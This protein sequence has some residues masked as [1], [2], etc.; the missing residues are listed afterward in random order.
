VNRGDDLSVR[1][2][3]Q[4]ATASE[5]WSRINDTG[6]DK[7]AGRLVRA[8]WSGRSVRG[9][10]DA[11]HGQL[12]RLISELEMLCGRATEAM[13][14]A[15]RALA[16]MDLSLSEQVIIDDAETGRIHTQFEQSACRLLALQ[17][18]VAG[19]LRAVVSMIEVGEKVRRMSGL[20]CHVAEAAR[21][22]HPEPAVPEQLARRF[23]EMGQVGVY[24]CRQVRGAVDRPA[25]VDVGELDRLDDR[26]DELEA[27]VLVVRLGFDLVQ[28]G[29]AALDFGDDVLGGGFPDEGF[30][31]VVP[32]FGPGGDGVGEVGDAGEHAAT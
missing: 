1:K 29:A 19:E 13:S 15:A 25:T 5:L 7:S 2:A 4:V 11:Y 21:R 23:T 3:Y 28:G 27:S 32:V 6:F 12:G 22:R 10:R 14:N 18:P 9:M 26:V 20:A 30:R 17:A 31:V 16:Y 8:W 24:L